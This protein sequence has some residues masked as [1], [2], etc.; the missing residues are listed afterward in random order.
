M[1]VFVCL[2]QRFWCFYCSTQ[3]L[4]YILWL[5]GWCWPPILWI[6]IQSSIHF[7]KFKKILSSSLGLVESKQLTLFKVVIN[8]THRG[9]PIFDL[10]FVMIRASQGSTPIEL[11]VKF[12]G[13][14]AGSIDVH[15]VMIMSVS[16]KGLICKKKE[17][18][19]FS[20]V[21]CWWFLQ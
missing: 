7:V 14:G 17:I 16:W 8:P 12:I 6:L 18:F 3:L 21:W 13:V 4:L 11:N 1:I 10:P 20:S 5:L 19:R 9:I 2:G 15:T